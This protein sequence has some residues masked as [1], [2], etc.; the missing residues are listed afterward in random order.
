M[1][2]YILCL[3]YCVLY[4]QG[5]VCAQS[6][7]I[8]NEYA[9]VLNGVSKACEEII[10]VDTAKG[11]NIGDQL[12]MIQMDGAS[13]DSSNTSS[14]GDIL[15]YN[16]AGKFQYNEILEI[17][18]NSIT[19]K[20]RV[21]EN[22]DYKNAAVQI[23][24]FNKSKSFTLRTAP[25]VRNWNGAK[26]GVLFIKVEDT[27]EILADIDV[28][29]KGFIGGQ[30]YLTA[31]CYCNFL[32]YYCDS[33]KNEGAKKGEGIGKVS[34]SKK[35]GRGKQANGGGGGNDVNAG[36]A[37]G[38]NGGEGGEGGDQYIGPLWAGCSI[39]SLTTNRKIGGKG[40]SKLNSD[41]TRLFL[42]GG[43]GAGHGNQGGNTV[44]GSGGGII[45]FSAK[46]I[47][48]NNKYIRSNGNESKGCLVSKCLDD[49]T[50]GGGGG[51]T[52]MIDALSINNGLNIEALG[53]KGADVMLSLTSFAAG[54][55]PGGGGGGGLVA[56]T[57]SS[58]PSTVS[59][60]TL[61]GK[62]GVIP[63][64]GDS[65]HGARPGSAGVIVYNYKIP[66][67]VLA[68]TPLTLVTKPDTLICE[69]SGSVVT[70]KMFASGGDS[71]TWSPAALVDLPTSSSPTA[72]VSTST[73]FMVIAKNASGC[74]D[75]GYI[76]IKIKESANVK[77]IE[78]TIK[79]CT[80]DST[81]LTAV[82]ASNYRWGLPYSTE[83]STKNTLK[84]LPT[85]SKYYFVEGKD[86]IGCTSQDS[87]FVSTITPIQVKIIEKYFETCKGDTLHLEASGVKKYDWM[88]KGL[89]LNDTGSKVDFINNASGI[90]YVIG[91]DENGCKSKDSFSTKS[92]VPHQ[93]S[94]MER[95]YEACK[96]DSV[97]VK[98]VGVKN[99]EWIPNVNFETPFE[100]SSLVLV[101]S[102]TKLFV[103]GV[104]ENGCKSI[105]S[106]FV[107]YNTV[108]PVIIK[109]KEL[110][111]C[112][113]DNIEVEAT[114]VRYY[115]WIP[116][117]LFTPNNSAKT[118]FIV[119]SN[120]VYYV[121]GIDANGC[122]SI[123]SFTVSVENPPQVT[124]LQDQFSGCKGDIIEL[125]AT[126]VNHYVWLPDYNF[127]NPTES[128]TRMVLVESGTFIVKGYNNINCVSY[129]TFNVNVNPLPNVKI[130]TS[131]KYLNCLKNDITLTATGAQ[132][133]TWSPA[134]IFNNPTSSSSTIQLNGSAYVYVK[135]IDGN[136]CESADSV[137]IEY[138]GDAIVKFPNA[139]T[140]NN[141]SYNDEFK[142]IVHC[143]KELKEFLI[144]DRWGNQMFNTQVLDEGWD[145]TFGGKPCVV[146]VYY[147]LYII[148]SWSGVEVMYKGDV[149]LIR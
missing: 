19:L 111:G 65:A 74:I 8:I 47:I 81:M 72:S 57:A 102:T 136:G 133:Y 148:K 11:F 109:D 80:N 103:K 87:V 40:G 34:I 37:G 24:G 116:D 21:T 85:V 32:G 71:Y 112:K 149:T 106:F 121:I 93:V 130:Q 33:L 4:L 53:G 50:G 16:S 20:H 26:G 134:H 51:G 91:T 147:Y 82:G 77:I 48:G 129:D 88:P 68:P 105:D 64:Y 5:V 45:L 18:G 95:V 66:T 10:D 36:G 75:T 9:K 27:L 7:T 140:P 22:F 12:L 29:G 92:F 67:N 76:S 108:S 52:I 84:I 15:K 99:Y 25:T 107:K 138:E 124:I 41:S 141:D 56:T 46:T 60:S 118:S 96:G 114:G 113:G 59:I 31:I 110:S 3:I 79:A 125:E 90:F 97:H 98:A 142:P 132:N 126:G 104:D 73:T 137:R 42:G 6:T 78:D 131:G 145:G 117:S 17:K 49:G 94:V 14:F 30:T 70:Y 39:S 128:K 62:N 44:G 13:I 119:D 63:Y 83:Y 89:Y 54:H 120:G 146:G 43:G 69:K 144:Y 38:S 101:D 23:V 139:F 115:S 123:D 2:K 61:G 28:S 135:G 55:G 122:K 143:A 1:K 127:T 100:S 86:D 35:F 58:L